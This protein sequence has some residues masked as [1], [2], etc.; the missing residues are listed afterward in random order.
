MTNDC[1]SNDERLTINDK[2]LTIKIEGYGFRKQDE[3]GEFCGD[4]EKDWETIVYGCE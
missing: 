4:E 1:V 2:R 3:V